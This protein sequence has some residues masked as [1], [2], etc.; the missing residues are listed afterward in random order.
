ML[1]GRR[2]VG[3]SEAGA[4]RRADADAHLGIATTGLLLLARIS[5]CPPDQRSWARSAEWDGTSHSLAA[6][7]SLL[8]QR[9]S[10]YPQRAHSLGSILVLLDTSTP[11][12]RWRSAVRGVILNAA[13]FVSYY[14]RAFLVR[15]RDAIRTLQDLRPPEAV[16]A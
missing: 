12:G 1:M 9:S 11:I 3:P 15:E 4:S 14:E 2:Y 16:V 13:C 8:V 10:A 6:I 5:P 7:S